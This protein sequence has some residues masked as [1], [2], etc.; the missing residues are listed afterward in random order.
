MTVS[1]P[2]ENIITED[3]E[4]CFKIKVW[5]RE[6]TFENSIFPSSIVSI[7]EELLYAPISLETEFGGES[8]DM[9][10]V[11][12]RVMECE[13]DKVVVASSALC[14]NILVNASTTVEYDGFT[15]ISLRLIPCGIFDMITTRQSKKDLTPI[16]NRASLSVKLNKKQASLLHFWPNTDSSV[17]VR[18]VINSGFFFEGDMP[19]KPCLWA[20]NE[21]CGLNICM[22]TDEGIEISDKAKCINTL[23]HDDYNEIKI[24]LLDKVPS[25]WENREEDWLA[26][27]EPLCFD[28]MLEA[29]PVKKPMENAI[30]EW[31]SYQV[32]DFKLDID[33]LHKNGVKWVIFHEDWSLIQNY[34]LAADEKKMRAAID[35]CHELGMK[36]MLYF[37]YEYSSAMVDFDKNSKTYLNRDVEG[38]PTGGWTREGMYQKAF[39][40]CYKGGYSNGMIE[41][42][43]KAMDYYGADG[44]YTDGT[45]VPWECANES[46]GCGY[47]DNN[48]E[49]HVTYP[50]KAVREHVKRLSYEIHKR[51]GII[52]THQSACCLMPTLAFCD[53]YFDGENIQGVLSKELDKFLKLDAFRCEYTGKNFGIVPNF[54]AYLQP[55]HYT[56]R[57]VLSIS[58]IHNV[59]ARPRDIE[60]LEVVGKVWDAYDRFGMADA[61]EKPY[62]EGSS[63]VTCQNKNVYITSFEKAN[64]MLAAVSKFSDKDSIEEICVPEGFGVAYEIFEGKEYPVTDGKINCQIDAVKS[65]MFEIK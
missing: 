8:C 27:L 48:G 12:H 60:T 31:R 43:A 53:T 50:I 46:H 49:L 2:W 17:L 9:Y 23:E 36:V 45:F 42:A 3:S 16:L 57:N 28:F 20:G 47:R 30:N 13:E 1:V 10:N 19:F 41:S 14:G 56:I 55:P 37:G 63:S 62:W 35:R 5:G 51:G 33:A 54:I 59:L 7:G 52:D 39:I 6:Y 65:Y 38:R 58:L 44:I 21:N 40:A 4:N 22:E 11:N 34:C 61:E 26:P 24:N 15:D 29:T 25:K 64:K 18:G 32:Y